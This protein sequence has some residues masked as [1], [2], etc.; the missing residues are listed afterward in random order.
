MV[1]NIIDFNLDNNQ[2][3]RVDG[4]HEKA[5][6]INTLT[7]CHGWK[8]RWREFGRKRAHNLVEMGL[9]GGVTANSLTLGGDSVK[10]AALS[11]VEWDNVMASIRDKG[12]K[13]LSARDIKETKEEGRSGYIINFQRSHF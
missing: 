13:I 12:G 8:S 7:G 1:E 3:D 10:E 2:R 9:K 4:L 6:V 5:Y 11:I